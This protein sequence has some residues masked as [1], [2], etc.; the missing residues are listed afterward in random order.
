MTFFKILFTTNLGF[1]YLQSLY[2]FNRTDAFTGK[3]TQQSSFTFEQSAILFNLG[4]F[5]VLIF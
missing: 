1:F 4:K 3:F 2:L 5:A